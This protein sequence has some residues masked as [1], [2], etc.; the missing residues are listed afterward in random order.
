MTLGERICKLRTER[1]LSQGDLA[2]T[3]DVS[4]QSISKWET[5]GSVPELDK[6]VKLSELFEISLDE[7]VRDKKAEEKTQREQNVVY[8]EKAET[9]SGKKIIGVILLCFSA[10]IWL[11][12]SLFGDV[13]AGLLLAS[14]FLGC[15]LICLLVRCNTGLW[16]SWV[17]YL[18]IS[19]YMRFATGANWAYALVP[20]MYTGGRTVHLVIAWTILLIFTVL[21]LI[22]VLRFRKKPV[23]TIKTNVIGTAVAWA[24]YLAARFISMPP[25]DSGNVDVT[26]IMRYRFASSAFGWCREIF[27]VVALVFTVRLITA[28]IHKR[29]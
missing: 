22:T 20:Q 9:H 26:Q 24:V 28:L 29:K 12:V 3:L 2:E 7:L 5:N 21:T 14:P 15:G 16:C 23:T 18:F 8:V 11:L 1:N 4:R 25:V 10:F 6:L 27:I 13:L 17:V 19:L